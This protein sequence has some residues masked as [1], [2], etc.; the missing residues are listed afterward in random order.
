[1]IEYSMTK[2]MREET[3]AQIGRKRL[4][5]TSLAKQLGL[6]R[7]HLTSMINGKTKGSVEAWIALWELIELEPYL[8]RK[9]SEV[10]E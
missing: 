2:E 3:R 1:M 10:G 6:T 5:I 7:P 8:R 4:S 9:D